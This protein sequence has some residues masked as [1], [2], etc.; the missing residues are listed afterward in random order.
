MAQTLQYWGRTKYK[1]Y[2]TAFNL[3]SHHSL[4]YDHINFH[5]EHTANYF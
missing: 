3:Y 2:E 5:V 1:D 4:N